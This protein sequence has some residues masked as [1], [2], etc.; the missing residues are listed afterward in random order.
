MLRGLSGAIRREPSVLVRAPMPALQVRWRTGGLVG[1]A[2]TVAA[3]GCLETADRT[4]CPSRDQPTQRGRPL[5]T[6]SGGSQAS[7][8]CP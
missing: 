2:A 7:C 6:C 3:S 8:L 4:V 5:D 1:V